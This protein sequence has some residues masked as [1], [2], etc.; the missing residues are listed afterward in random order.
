M[1][2]DDLNMLG[3]NVFLILQ[4]I[5]K[6]IKLLELFNSIWPG[7]VDGLWR[8]RPEELTQSIYHKYLLTVYSI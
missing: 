7:I 5:L 4:M 1:Y 8:I 2:I 6:W 3:I